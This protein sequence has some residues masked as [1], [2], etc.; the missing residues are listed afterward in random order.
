MVVSAHP[1][2]MT[3][4]SPGGPRYGGSAHGPAFSDADLVG[5]PASRRARFGGGILDLI[6]VV[7]VVAVLVGPTIQWHRLGRAGYG[8]EYVAGR[9]GTRLAELA[10]L[11]I[12]FLYFWLQ[13]GR[14]GRTIGKRAAG[15]RLVRM[16]DGGA[17]GWRQAAWRTGFPILFFF[18]AYLLT[19]GFGGILVLLDP[20][21]I[22]WDPRR[23]AL[24]DKVAATLVI[25]VDPTVPDPY[26]TDRSVPR[27]TST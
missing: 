10:A 11:V 8:T 7:L 26:A 17:V 19:C 15:T 21:W 2:G 6:I 14:W 12:G 20:G 4:P 25:K 16:T 13:H 24:H 1:L 5:R 23:Q 22:L 18:V 3:H 27:S 9:P